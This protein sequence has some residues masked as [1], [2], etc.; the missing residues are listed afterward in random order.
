MNWCLFAW[1]LFAAALWVP[2]MVVFLWMAGRL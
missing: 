2:I 1:G